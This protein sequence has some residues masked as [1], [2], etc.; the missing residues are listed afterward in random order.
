M[1]VIGVAEILLILVVG[2]FI[3]GPEKLPQVVKKFG[4]TIGEFLHIKEEV[5]ESVKDVKDSID[6]SVN[7]VKDTIDESV[8][9]TKEVIN[10]AISDPD[11]LAGKKEKIN[12]KWYDD[13]F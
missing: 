13:V 9:E 1:G 5:E 7:D 8:N 12:D 10:N 4:K 6:E 11:K 2:F 3:F